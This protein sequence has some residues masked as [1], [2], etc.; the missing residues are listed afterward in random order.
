MMD[1]IQENWIFL[2]VILSY[3]I[4]TAFSVFWIMKNKFLGDKQKR[5]NIIMIILFPF[6]ILIIRSILSPLKNKGTNNKGWVKQESEGRVV[7]TWFS[8]GN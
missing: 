1:F 3:L 7:G 2:L 8:G 6:W 4:V 5:M